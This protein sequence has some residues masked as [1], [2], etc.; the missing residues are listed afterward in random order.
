MASILPIATPTPPRLSPMAAA[1]ASPAAASASSVTAA[2]SGRKLLGACFPFS[3]LLARVFPENGVAVK[4]GYNI[5]LLMG[6]FF[7]LSGEDRRTAAIVETT[8][9][10]EIFRTSKARAFQSIATETAAVMARRMEHNQRIARQDIEQYEALT[11]TLY[12][13]PEVLHVDLFS[14]QT[15]LWNNYLGYENRTV[16][17]VFERFFRAFP[18]LESLNLPYCNLTDRDLESL[19]ACIQKR[20]MCAF[21]DLAKL[22]TS[23]SSLAEDVAICKVAYEI[24]DPSYPQRLQQLIDRCTGDMK[25][26]ALRCRGLVNLDFAGSPGITDAGLALIL[27]HCPQI[28]RLNLENCTINEE[29]LSHLAQRGSQLIYLNL[30]NCPTSGSLVDLFQGCPNLQHLTLGSRERTTDEEIVALAESCSRLQGLELN[31]CEVSDVA[32]CLLARCRYLRTL[33]LFNLARLTDISIRRVALGCPLLQILDLDQC[34]NITN[35][36][37]EVLAQN[38]HYLQE[39]FLSDT[40]ITDASLRVVAARCPYLQCL[41]VSYCRNITRESLIAFTGKEPHL[42]LRWIDIEGCNISYA[43]PIMEILLKSCPRLE[44]IKRGEQTLRVDRKTD[45]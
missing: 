21:D 41:R 37:I 22:A 38:C 1:A 6:I 29:G 9:L 39:L 19:T 44:E 16:S 28:Q 2:V 12:S 14:F 36:S 5:P 13:S 40:E 31:D 45:L 33:R 18:N 43:D 4:T 23:G 20:T 3:R 15:D 24:S 35:E 26:L 25:I 32:I 34:L 10:P 8:N 27:K 30:R 42:N 7:Y 11:G 17:G